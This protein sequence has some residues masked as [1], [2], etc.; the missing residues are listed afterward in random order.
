MQAACH[1][2]LLNLGLKVY[3]VD[4]ILCLSIFFQLRLIENE[5]T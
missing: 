4:Y 5:S 2:L 3:N 1:H